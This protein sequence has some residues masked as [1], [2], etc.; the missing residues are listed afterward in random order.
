MRGC[1]F[2]ADVRRQILSQFPAAQ[3]YTG[4]VSGISVQKIDHR[5]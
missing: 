4:Q 3:V 1:E 5:E 2:E